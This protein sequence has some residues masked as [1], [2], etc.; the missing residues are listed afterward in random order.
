VRN[1]TLPEVRRP[2]P[3]ATHPLNRTAI[4]RLTPGRGEIT[5]GPSPQR[6]GFPRG[7]PRTPLPPPGPA[8]VSAVPLTAGAGG[9]TTPAQAAI[10]CPAPGH[11]NIRQRTSAATRARNHE[12]MRTYPPALP[13]GR[14][15]AETP[16]RRG[17]QR[18]QCG[19][20]HRPHNTC[21]QIQTGLSGTVASLGL[22]LIQP[23]GAQ[24]TNTD[25]YQLAC[26]PAGGV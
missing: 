24:T 25:R 21:L 7:F 10:L 6:P 15:T 9:N 1:R 4:G 2:R 20:Y 26:C 22:R 23:L 12:A 3:L 8:L 16:N 19:S 5:G 14:R 13:R 11:R 18:P 17:S